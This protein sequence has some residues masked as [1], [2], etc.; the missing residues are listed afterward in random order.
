M[1]GAYNIIMMIGCYFMVNLVFLPA[2]TNVELYFQIDGHTARSAVTY[3]QFG[4]VFSCVVAA[5]FADYIGKKRFLIVGLSL[6]LLGT[7]V[8][9]TT[10]SFMIFNVGRFLQGMG[11]ATGFM[12]GFAFAVDLYEPEKTLKIIALNGVITSLVSVFTPYIGGKLTTIWG[13]RATF[14]FMIPF[15]ILTIFNSYKN[16]PSTTKNENTSLNFL[17]S[18]YEIKQLFSSRLYIGYAVLNGMLLGA[19]VYCL[20]LFPF[21]YK[22]TF[23]LQEDEVGIIIGVTIWFSFGLMSLLSVY[24]YELFGIDRTIYLGFSICLSVSLV[25]GGIFIFTPMDLYIFISLIFMF[26][27]GF[28]LIYSGSISQSM[29]V[30]KDLTTKASALRTVMLSF[31]PLLGSIAAQYSPDD[32]VYYLAGGLLTGVVFSLFF[33]VR[34]NS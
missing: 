22:K 18:L 5:F 20:N 21:F 19:V 34:R 27:A 13:W 30:Y 11:A 8:C 12:M 23:G 24:L 15:F 17:K 10:S 25:L 14:I 16:I 33:F 32:N 7:L 4:A 29:S 26:C 31:F 9:A 3:M 28:G 2:L 1:K 6:A